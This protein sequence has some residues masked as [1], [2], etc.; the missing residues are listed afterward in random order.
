MGNGANDIMRPVRVHLKRETFEITYGCRPDRRNE[1]NMVEVSV[2]A[3]L[4]KQP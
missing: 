3:N 2:V 4:Q 1:T